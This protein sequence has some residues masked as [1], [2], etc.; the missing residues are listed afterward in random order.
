MTIDLMALAK[1]ADK[2]YIDVECSFGTM[3][4]YHVPDAVLLAGSLGFNEPE[5][6]MVPMKTATGTQERVSKKGDRVFD[7]WQ[8]ELA[9]HRERAFT[10]RQ[11]K[12]FILSLQDLNWE[13]I[14]TNQPPPVKLAQTTYKDNWPENEALQK[15]IWL[16]FTILTIREDK[17]KILDAM[18][19][20]NE[21]H[22][23]S[24]EMV[25]E[26]KKNSE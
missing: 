6:P 5:Q 19:T 8:A 4:V 18:T 12:G 24:D 13:G 10:L 17:S 21:S 14:D 20:M 11:A 2:T 1:Q 22:E 26:V 3:R 16:D 9:D 25:E 7:E 15:M 23:P